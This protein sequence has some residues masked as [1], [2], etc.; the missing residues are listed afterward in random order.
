MA[1]DEV[2]V[3]SARQQQCLEEVALRAREAAQALEPAGP[4]VAADAVIA[5]LE[6]MDALT[7]ADTREA[8]LDTLFERFCIGK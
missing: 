4:A 3:A 2:V 8:V 5:A 1:S 7:G 6:A